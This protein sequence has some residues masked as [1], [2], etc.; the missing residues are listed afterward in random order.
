MDNKPELL[1]SLLLLENQIRDL[2]LVSPN[3]ELKEI[4]PQV[5]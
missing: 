3:E 4:D 5:W 1:Q 2:G